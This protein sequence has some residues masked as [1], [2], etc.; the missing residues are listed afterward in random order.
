MVTDLKCR[1]SRRTPIFDAKGTAR[2]AS[3]A[4]PSVA[5]STSAQEAQERSRPLGGGEGPE[6]GPTIRTA[7]S[8]DRERGDPADDHAQP[9]APSPSE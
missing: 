8:A 6:P 2:E 3:A 5:H 7:G 1:S 4:E 9:I